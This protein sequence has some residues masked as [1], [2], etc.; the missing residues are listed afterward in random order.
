MN[1][2]RLGLFFWQKTCD[3][4]YPFFFWLYSLSIPIG[5]YKYYYQPEDQR[6]R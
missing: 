6:Q 1:S 4:I 5:W 2:F 3:L